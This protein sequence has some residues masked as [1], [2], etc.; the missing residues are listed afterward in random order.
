VKSS[1]G[2]DPK[3]R[4]GP[5]LDSTAHRYNRSGSGRS[6]AGFK[7]LVRLSIL[8]TFLLFNVY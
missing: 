6:A 7:V 3:P 8:K 2:V 5:I 4:S 1:P